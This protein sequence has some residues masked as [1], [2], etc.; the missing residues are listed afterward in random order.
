[1]NL[2]L[3]PTVILKANWTNP[4]FYRDNDPQNLAARQNFNE[5]IGILTWAF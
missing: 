2:Y 4:H 5:F 3:R 1:M